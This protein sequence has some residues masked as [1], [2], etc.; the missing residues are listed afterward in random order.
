M[1]ASLL[2]PQLLTFVGM[3]GTVVKTLMTNTAMDV[4]SGMAIPT[5]SFQSHLAINQ[6]TVGQNQQNLGI[7][8]HTYKIKFG[9]FDQR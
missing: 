2:I 5:I 4:K 6:A 7:F 1:S 9:P 8:G 3:I